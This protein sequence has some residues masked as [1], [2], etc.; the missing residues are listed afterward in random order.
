MARKRCRGGLKRTKL[1]RLRMQSKSEQPSSCHRSRLGSW[2]GQQGH[3]PRLPEPK[4][5]HQHA[6]AA[7]A[8]AAA[9]ESK[10]DRSNSSDSG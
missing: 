3:A 4:Q 2:C 8:A 5:H 10:D 7:S 6:R 9:E 1:Q